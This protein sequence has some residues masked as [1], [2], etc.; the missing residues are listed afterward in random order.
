MTN[1]NGVPVTNCSLLIAYWNR[2]GEGLARNTEYKCSF[3]LRVPFI[4]YFLFP[5][6]FHS[7]AGAQ[8]EIF[9]EFLSRFSSQPL[10]EIN[11]GCITTCLLRT[12]LQGRFD[13]QLR[14][15]KWLIVFQRTLSLLGKAAAMVSDFIAI[16]QQTKVDFHFN[17][18]SLYLINCFLISGFSEAQL[19]FSKLA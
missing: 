10:T 1:M 15:K 7:I 8:W 14:G 13:Q 3:R 4:K 16:W 12:F 18:M 9:N 5:L 2:K 6:L 17:K 19:I 11:H